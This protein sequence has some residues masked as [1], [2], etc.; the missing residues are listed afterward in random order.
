MSEKV[1][2]IF[3]ILLANYVIFSSYDWSEDMSSLPARESLILKIVLVEIFFNQ[4]AQLWGFAAKNSCR[5]L[6]HQVQLASFEA[7]ADKLFFFPEWA[8]DFPGKRFTNKSNNVY[9]LP[10]TFFTFFSPSAVKALRYRFKNLRLV[11]E[12]VNFCSY[13][14]DI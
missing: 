1:F 14:L 7:A 13:L 11:F 2:P 9:A 4:S 10:V 6:S 12:N 8:T 3:Y 5:Q